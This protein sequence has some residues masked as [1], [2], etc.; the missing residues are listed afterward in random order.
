MKNLFLATSLSAIL[1]LAAHGND[2]SQIR[3]QISLKEKELADLQKDLA[4]LR[5]QLSEV[6]SSSAT[7]VSSTTR[8]T[9]KTGDTIHS[10][11]RRHEVSPTALMKW[12]KITDPTKL[13]VGETLTI[14]A[15]VPQSSEATTSP[16]PVKSSKS[17]PGKSEAYTVAKGDTFYAIA[18]RHK[19]TLKELKSLNPEVSPHLIAVGQTL[20]V[21][22]PSAPSGAKPAPAP[23]KT[24][25][26]KDPVRKPAPARP[27]PAAEKSQPVA[28]KQSEEKPKAAPP[29]VTSKKETPVPPSPSIL[30]DPEPAPVASTV[31][32]DEEVTFEEFA[33]NHGTSTEILNKL[34]GWSL[35]KATLLAR[36]SEIHVPN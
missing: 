23:R 15:E 28:L 32:L 34:N 33:K 21:A 7:T 16:S 29:K 22:V 27:A 24:Y 19:M 17:A 5:E 3:A 1:S 6:T 36:G 31:I 26:I 14:S 35:P 2:Q 30:D 8:Y 18:R 12:N 25:Q 11:A 20:Q 13:A 9:V 10:I 4:L